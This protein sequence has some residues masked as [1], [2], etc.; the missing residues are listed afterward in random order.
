[1]RSFHVCGAGVLPNGVLLQQSLNWDRELPQEALDNWPTLGE[2]IL[3]LNLQDVGG[4]RHETEPLVPWKRRKQSLKK[5][6]FLQC[7]GNREQHNVAQ[8]T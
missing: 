2:L 6:T 8:I 3:D 4:K 7:V 1:M 5:T